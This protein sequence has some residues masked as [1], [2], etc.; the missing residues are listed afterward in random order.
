MATGTRLFC[1]A[2]ALLTLGAPAC[3]APVDGTAV[4]APDL[5]REG[6]P[7]LNKADL[8]HILLDEAEL[9]TRLG[10][11]PGQYGTTV[12]E[13]AVILPSVEASQKFV[14]DSAQAWSNCTAKALSRTD[15][16][17]WHAWQLHDVARDG[18]IVSQSSQWAESDGWGCQHSMAAAGNAVLETSVC[19]VSIRDEGNSLL[20]EMITNAAER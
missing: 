1:S 2:A 14:D 17:E 7:L 19:S 10:A 13:T 16:G 5:L 9:H 11:E 3:A 18:E 4:R 8:E 12:E 20:A 6:R 15:G